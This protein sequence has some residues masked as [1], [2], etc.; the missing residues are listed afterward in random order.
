MLVEIHVSTNSV[1]VIFRVN[2]RSV[3]QF[4]FIALTHLSS[5]LSLY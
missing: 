1:E 3:I 4:V 5:D 2:V